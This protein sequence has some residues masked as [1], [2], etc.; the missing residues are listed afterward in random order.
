MN[1]ARTLICLFV[2]LTLFFPHSASAKPKRGITRLEVSEAN[3]DLL[4]RAAALGSMTLVDSRLLII[5]LYAISLPGD[6]V[7]GAQETC[8][9]RY[10][11]VTCSLTRPAVLKAYDLGEVGE[12]T[13]M[14]FDGKED[15]TTWSLKGTAQNYPALALKKNRRLAKREASFSLTLDE[16]SL[17][18]D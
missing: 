15:Q 17:D 12:I 11:L 14:R 18:A 9:H 13:K 4:I 8:G 10:V 16:N 1:T 3:R 5:R 7:P 2:L 6:C